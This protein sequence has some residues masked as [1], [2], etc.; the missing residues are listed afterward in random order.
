M[1]THFFPSQKL[2]ELEKHLNDLKFSDTDFVKSVIE[3]FSEGVQHGEDIIL[4]KHY[5]VPIINYG[6]LIIN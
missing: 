4:S 6:S 1:A 5:D 3:K 2:P